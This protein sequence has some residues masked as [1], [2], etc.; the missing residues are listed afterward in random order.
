[1]KKLVVIIALL[2]AQISIA[3]N[4]P[5]E[6]K[7]TDFEFHPLQGEQVLFVDQSSKKEFKGV[8]SET[9]DIFIS[10]PAGK[11]DI[12]IKSVGDAEDFSTFE[13]PPLPAGQNYRKASMQIQIAETKMF[14]L[15]N[16]HFDTGKWSI[17]SN[18]YKEL[19]ELAEFLSLKKD[20]KIEIGGHTDS[21]G[22]E[23]AN[24][25]LSQKRAEAV[26]KYLVSK[27]ISASRIVAKGY[28]ESNPIADN[29][30]DK[31]K[32]L[33]RRTEVKIL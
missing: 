1:M 24:Q 3:Q 11:Y 27:G 21:D 25:S 10:L 2:I 5:L 19:D 23:L 28:G 16:V 4:A 18:S 32:A 14:T 22:D 15:D 26:K 8:S 33:N 12:K 31:G 7:V 13:V 20:K 29:N 30:T 17:K 9:G 6:I